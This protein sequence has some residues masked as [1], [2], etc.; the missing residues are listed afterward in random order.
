[1][2]RLAFSVLVL[3]VLMV[4]L[5]LTSPRMALVITVAVVLACGLVAWLVLRLGGW[6][7]PPAAPA[8]MAVLAYPLWSWRRLESSLSSMARETTRI[9]A[10]MRRDAPAAAA[11]APAAPLLVA[12]FL[13]PVESRIAAISGAVDR[14]AAAIVVDG[15]SDG[16][17]REEMM[18]HL[19][20]D[21]RSPLVSLRALAE[22]LRGGGS[23]VDPAMLARIDACAR[24][25]LELTEQFLLLGRAQAL[26]AT[27][28]NE[29]DLVQLFHQSADDLWEDAQ[30]EGARVERVCALDIALVRGDAR[31]LQRALMNLGWNALR[32][33]PRGA[34]ITLSLEAADPE[35]FDLTVHDTGSGFAPEQLQSM[36]QAYTQGTTAGPGFGLGLALVCLVADKHKARIVAFHAPGG[37]FSIRLRIPCV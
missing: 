19:A 6:W 9:A 21:L 32:H 26:D 20:H 10:L 28:F 11:P 5:L 13:D 29:V 37:G 27:L 33:G 30:R 36:M 17:Y 25:S 1:V 8:A 24:R 7:W 2:P 22:Q 34:T 23:A 35:G 18:R 4:A 16:R 15:G 12:G 14:I 3:V 31:L